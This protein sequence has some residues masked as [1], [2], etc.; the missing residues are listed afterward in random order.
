MTDINGMRL[1]PESAIQDIASA[2]RSVNGGT[3]SYK[4]SQMARAVSALSVNPVDYIT[5]WLNK[6]MSGEL[7][8]PSSV[9]EI[10]A[11]AFANFSNLTLASFPNCSI[12]YNYAFQSCYS[13]TTISFPACT[14]IGNSVFYSCSSL[15][16]GAVF[17]LCTYIGS[18]AFRG[19]ELYS[20]SAPLCISIG[21]SAFVSPGKTLFTYNYTISLPECISIGAYAFSGCNSIYN[22]SLPKCR[23]LGDHVFQYC[24]KLSSIYLP[25]CNTIH[26]G[27]FSACY[28]LTSINLPQLTILSSE[29]FHSC[30]HLENISVPKVAAIWSSAL[31]QCYALSILSLPSCS[32]IAGSY[33]FDY[34][35]NLLSLYLMSTSVVVLSNSNTFNNTPIAGVTTSTGGVYGSIYVPASLLA[36]YKAATNWA[37]FSDRIVGV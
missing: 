7:I 6:T 4:A 26:W 25:L 8:A 14:S 19:A 3:S 32:L 2:I 17:P 15:R 23:T 13:L 11:F 27:C 34:C 10:D 35:Y 30:F 29:T 22:V 5:P 20:L 21:S 1:Y 28:S 18:N 33:A 31:F 16:Y 9:T 12:I 24:S 37:T 36:S